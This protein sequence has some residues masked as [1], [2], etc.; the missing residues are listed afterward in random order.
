[1]TKEEYVNKLN[2][3]KSKIYNSI[4][5]AVVI[6]IESTNIY[7]HCWLNEEQTFLFNKL[8]AEIIKDLESRYPFLTFYYSNLGTLIE[9]GLKKEKNK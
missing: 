5:D 3:K 2:E 8:D 1:M 9:W 6:E 4:I 7:E